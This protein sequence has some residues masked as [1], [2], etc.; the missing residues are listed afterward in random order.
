MSEDIVR[1]IV[2][3]MMED[4]K[5]TSGLVTFDSEQD[6][7]EQLAYKAGH[8]AR[9]SPRGIQTAEFVYL[10]SGAPDGPLDAGTLG[11]IETRRLFGLLARAYG[12]G[13]ADAALIAGVKRKASILETINYFMDEWED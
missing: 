7:E 3:Q 4:A 12:L 1:A 8:A 9:F 5:A 2:L 6:S 10:A 13:V 11:P